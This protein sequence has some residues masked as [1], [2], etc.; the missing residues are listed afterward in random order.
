M[1]KLSAVLAIIASAS[2]IG[3]MPAAAQ[4]H[5]SGHTPPTHRATVLPDG[6]RL[7]VQIAGD[8]AETV[9]MIREHIRQ[10]SLQMAAGELK[11]DALKCAPGLEGI[12]A[13]RSAITF[14]YADLPK[15][16]SLTVVTRDPNALRAIHQFINAHPKADGKASHGASSAHDPAA[17]HHGAAGGDMKACMAM[18][19]AAHGQL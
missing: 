13:A 12:A 2:F 4:N 5:P 1:K 16:A 6:G 10:F 14:K 18:H 3:A 15:G 17:A 19:G 9:A 11:G 7:D 8:D